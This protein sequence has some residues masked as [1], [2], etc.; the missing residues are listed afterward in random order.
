MQFLTLCNT[1]CTKHVDTKEQCN[2]SWLRLLGLP[3]LHF[4]VTVVAPHGMYC[5]FL[6]YFS[7]I[8]FLQHCVYLYMNSVMVIIMT[9][10][11][12]CII[13]LL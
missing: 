8:S 12:M 7:L 6:Y 13:V 1:Q 3:G 10:C 2:S 5:M 4:S 11:M 9:L